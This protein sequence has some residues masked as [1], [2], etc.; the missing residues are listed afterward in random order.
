MGILGSYVL[1]A[2]ADRIGNRQVFIIGFIVMSVALFCLPLA[3]EIWMLYILAGF[4]GFVGGGMGASESP[5]TAWLF[6]LGSHGLI[7]GVVHV[8]FTIGAAAGPFVT[9]YIFDLT[10]DYRLA[11]ATCATIGVVGLILTLILRSTKRPDTGC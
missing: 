4:F 9:G 10:G 5:L 3:G 11:F 7:Y 8:G 6:G 2:I 1:S